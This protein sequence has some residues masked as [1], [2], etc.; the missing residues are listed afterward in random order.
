M[1]FVLFGGLA[2]VIGLAIATVAFIPEAAGIK[3]P[4]DFSFEKGKGSLGVV[5]FSHEKHQAKNPKCTACHTKVFQMKR[6]KSGPI[7]MAAINQGK[8]CGTCHNGAKAF[9]VKTPADCK[10]CHVK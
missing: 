10:K 9:S 2:L 5:T 3:V 7:T 6:G 1:R 8:F 4:P